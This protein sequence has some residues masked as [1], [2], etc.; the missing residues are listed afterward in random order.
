MYSATVAFH[1][2]PLLTP[3]PQA[4]HVIWI[5]FAGNGHLIIFNGCLQWESAGAHHRP[6][7][8]QSG[9]GGR[10]RDGEGKKLGLGQSGQPGCCLIG[11]YGNQKCGAV[12]R[13]RKHAA[14]R[15]PWQGMASCCDDISIYISSVRWLGHLQVPLPIPLIIWNP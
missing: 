10:R 7:R 13:G 8:C 14:P 1:W 5:V 3:E 2:A 12:Q 4:S 11:V 6:C 9:A 15:L